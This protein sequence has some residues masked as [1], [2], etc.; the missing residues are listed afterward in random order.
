MQQFGVISR[1]TAIVY[2]NDLIRM[3]AR[4]FPHFL[5][6]PDGE[7]GFVPVENDNRDL[8]ILV[9]TP[10]TVP[11]GEVAVGLLETRVHTLGGELALVCGCPLTGRLRLRASGATNH[12]KR[13]T[14]YRLDELAQDEQQ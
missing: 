8:G 9:S 10:R 14:R 6:A 2:D 4:V 3:P 12:A 7:I 1:C 13:Q 5:Q 11:T